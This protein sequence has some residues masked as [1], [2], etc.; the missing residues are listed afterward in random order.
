MDAIVQ[1][2]KLS[3]QYRNFRLDNVSF[4]IPKG[5]IVGL[6]GENGAGKSTT[7]S[8]IV[9]LIKKTAAQSPFGDGSCL[10]PNS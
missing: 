9:D 1:V 6:I 2:E 4:S 8:A 10:Y 7:I 5:A 3:K